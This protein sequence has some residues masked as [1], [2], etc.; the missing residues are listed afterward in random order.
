MWWVP[1]P[2][3]VTHRHCVDAIVSLFPLRSMAVRTVNLEPE[4]RNKTALAKRGGFLERKEWTAERIVLP[5]LAAEGPNLP[6]FSADLERDLERTA[7]AHHGAT[8][9]L[10]MRWQSGYHLARMA[11]K[12]IL[13]P[14]AAGSLKRL[15]AHV[16]AW[17]KGAIQGH[18]RHEPTKVSRSRIK[19]LRGLRQPQYRLRVGDIRVFYDVTETAVEILAIVTK[20]QAQGWLDERGAE[21]A[22]GGTRS[23]QG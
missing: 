4:A 5:R 3:K 19:R 17:V 16:R 22:G 8:A 13:A 11:F 14:E 23:S 18:L 21:N 9:S 2:S 1:S 12:I 6:W 10:P 20:A 7:A 15:P